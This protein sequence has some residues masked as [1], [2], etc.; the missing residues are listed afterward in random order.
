MRTSIIISASDVEKGKHRLQVA[1]NHL[2]IAVQK[3]G[4]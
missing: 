4:V 1:G 2:T 3:Q